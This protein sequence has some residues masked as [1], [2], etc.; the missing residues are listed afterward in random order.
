MVDRHM[1][2]A[3]RSDRRHHAAVFV[4]RPTVVPDVRL[5]PAAAA[6]QLIKSAGLKV[7]RSGQSATGS[8]GPG[9]VA[10]Q[11]PAPSTKVP[12]RS[13]V[14]ITVSV[15]PVAADVPVVTGLTAEQ[16]VQKLSDALYLPTSVSVFGTAT[17]G[18]VLDQAPS[19]GTSWM[20][21]RPVAIGVA[22]ITQIND[23]QSNVV[24]DRLPQGGVVVRPGTTVLL[25]FKAP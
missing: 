21:G 15:S 14:D 9:L 5:K 4:K 22:V 25:L 8:V 3:R 10:R 24:V 7:G 19:P 2:R 6:T 23:P 17:A 12:S 16:A 18:V 11:S 13:S 1:H 20:T